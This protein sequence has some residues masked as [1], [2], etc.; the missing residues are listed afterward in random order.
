MRTKFTR[1][2]PGKDFQ[3]MINARLDEL[4]VPY[5]AENVARMGVKAGKG[6]FDYRIKLEPNI[7]FDAKSLGCN[8][9][10]MPPQRSSMV[11][12][13]QLKA[14]RVEYSNSNISGLL[15]Q[16]R[17]IGKIYWLGIDGL[18]Q[19]HCDLGL[20]S[21]ITPKMCEQYGKEIFISDGVFRIEELWV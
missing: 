14:L 15:I 19:L 9:L 6:K 21:C 20:K 16:Y 18:N 7:C 3:L 4:G 1:P 12:T 10:S 5:E 17:H 11:H 2:N 13:H 8:C